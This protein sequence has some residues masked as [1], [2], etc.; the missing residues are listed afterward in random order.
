MPLH[1]AHVLLDNFGFRVLDS[2]Q[3]SGNAAERRILLMGGLTSQNMGMSDLQDLGF[4]IYGLWF[5]V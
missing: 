4:G 5:R 2:T 1:L 3:K